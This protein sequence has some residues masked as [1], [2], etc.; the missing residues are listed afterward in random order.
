MLRTVLLL[1]VLAFQ[2]VFAGT[3]GEDWAEIVKLDAGPSAIPKN[4]AE[5]QDIAIRHNELQ[6]KNL[7]AFI[8]THAKDA[9]IFEARL[10][11][12]RVLSIRARLAGD[13]EPAEVGRILEELDSIAAGPQRAELDFAKLSRQMRRFQGKRPTADQRTELLD[14]ARAFQKSHPADHRVAAV[15]AEVATLFEHD[16]KTKAA[17]ITDAEKLAVEPELKAQLADDRKRL[18]LL[19]KPIG[20]RFT[21]IDRTNFDI[22]EHLGKVVVVLF[23]ATAS[24]PAK[25]AFSDLGEIIAQYEGV[26]WAAISLDPQKA[27]LEAFLRQQK[28]RPQTGWDGKMWGGELV[29]AL[30]INTLPTVWIFDKQGVLRT[31][32]GLE[33]ADRQISRLLR[34]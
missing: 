30:G 7:R 25:A 11:L 12:A 34:E 10:R 27:P 32:D 18:G 23:F 28:T 29:Q 33:Q 20:L 31:L 6:E 5:A 14:A 22:R 9:R 19:D 16:P 13:T 21:A 4:E 2:P 24:E 3:P 15:L 1:F 8:A 17:I 26:K